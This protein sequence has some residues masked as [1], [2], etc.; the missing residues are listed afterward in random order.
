MNIVNILLNL[1][2]PL[3]K[4]VIGRRLLVGPFPFSVF[5][6]CPSPTELATQWRDHQQR[7]DIHR[8][9]SKSRQEINPHG[10][11]QANTGKKSPEKIPHKSRHGVEDLDTYWSELIWSNLTGKVRAHASMN[12]ICGTDGFFQRHCN[13]W[14]NFYSIL[15]TIRK[16]NS[17]EHGNNTFGHGIKRA[18]LFQWRSKVTNLCVFITRLITWVGVVLEL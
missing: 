12:S 17:C 11:K 4:P 14:S 7:R 15:N 18:R 13:M 2:S 10:K 3:D 9:S 6:D 8:K 16:L 5:H 1:P